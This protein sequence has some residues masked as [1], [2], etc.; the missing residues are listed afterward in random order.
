VRRTSLTAVQFSA[1]RKMG[2]CL[3]LKAAHK[4][5]TCGWYFMSS[6]M[7]VCSKKARGTT[8]NRKELELTQVCGGPG[9]QG[10]RAARF[11]RP[12]KK[13]Q[14]PKPGRNHKESP[15]SAGGEAKRRGEAAREGTSG[16]A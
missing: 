2:L 14:Q 6:K 4:S 12:R 10:E 7:G 1:S 5:G 9:R 15:C 8:R 13:P 3:R 16:L 11:L